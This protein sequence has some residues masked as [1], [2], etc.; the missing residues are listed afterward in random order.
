MV[1][2]PG[3]DFHAL[4]MIWLVWHFP[5]TDYGDSTWH[6]LSAPTGEES[7]GSKRWWVENEL[8]PLQSGD[9]GTSLVV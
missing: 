4:Q 6:P 8:E 5:P 3:R 2:L 9:R 1:S 7:L